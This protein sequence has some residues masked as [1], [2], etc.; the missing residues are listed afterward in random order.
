MSFIHW[1]PGHIAKAENQ[2]KELAGLVD[3]C[4]EVR[5]SR[6]PFSSAYPNI[7]KITNSKPR[8]ILL[9]KSDLVETSL[10]N[11]WIEKIHSEKK[12]PTIGI[13][14]KTDRADIVKQ[15]AIELAKPAME[16]LKAKGL[17][18]RP[19]RILVLGMPNVGKSTLINKLIKKNKVKTGAKAGVTRQL[20]WVRIHPQIDLLDSPGIIPLTQPN[21]E[22]AFKLACVS[23]I[24]ENAYDN[25]F[26]SRKFC[27]LSVE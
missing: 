6:I 24:G 26:V 13:N 15:K 23:S 14:L 17:L 22:I 12:V 4:V 3:V 18:S 8:L 20:Q 16:R 9:N 1:Y 27:N 10:L 21:Q 11:K 2:L 25:E 7:E 19:V 5:D